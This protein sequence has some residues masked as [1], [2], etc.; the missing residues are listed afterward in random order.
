MH[1]AHL[2]KSFDTGPDFGVL[3]PGDWILHD[4]N[5]FELAFIAER[6]TVTLSTPDIA[7][8]PLVSANNPLVIRSGAWGDL[9]F[10][11]PLLYELAPTQPFTLSCARKHHCLFPNA[12]FPL[13]DYPVPLLDANRYDSVIDLGDVMETNRMMHATDA[14]AHALNVDEPKDYKPIYAVSFEESAAAFARYPKTPNHPRVAIQML[15]STPNKNY[16]LNDWMRVIVQLVQRG[17]EVMLLGEK[18]LPPLKGTQGMVHCCYIEG[19]DFRESAAILSTCDAF[20][21]IDSVFVHLCHALD[22]PA[23]GL[24]GPFPWAI[25]TSKA[26][27]TRSIDG[28]GACSPCFW[29]RHAGQSFPPNS[30]CTK[31]HQCAV[32]AT[33]KPEQIVAKVDALRP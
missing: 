19:F 18:V 2:T 14:F 15:A 3:T 33:I 29:H 9:L 24:Y 21:G 17:W 28:V 30:P 10:L 13:I 32:L 27:K 1:V 26:P 7:N 23:I 4:R 5:A 31:T 12:P 8:R 20:A 22:I 25:Y 11:S 6:A 16:P